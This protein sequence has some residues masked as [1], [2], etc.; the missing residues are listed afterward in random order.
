MPMC[1]LKGCSLHSALVVALHGTIC[2]FATIQART[3][4]NSAGV[5]AKGVRTAALKGGF[6]QTVQSAD[7]HGPPVSAKI[8]ALTARI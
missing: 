2:N 5:R 4:C 8:L 7:V 6:R 3:S 1:N